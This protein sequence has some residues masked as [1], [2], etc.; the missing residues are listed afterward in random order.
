MADPFLPDRDAVYLTYKDE[1][2]RHVSAALDIHDATYVPERPSNIYVVASR[3]SIA[4]SGQQ[5]P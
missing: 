2:I 3:R 1:I 4:S 5:S